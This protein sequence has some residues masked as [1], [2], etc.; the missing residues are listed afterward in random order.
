MNDQPLLRPGSGEN[1]PSWNRNDRPRPSFSVSVIR[2]CMDCLM[3]GI[4]QVSDLL[5]LRG[6]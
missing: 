3:L 5:Q 1:W 4:R 2:A 6:H